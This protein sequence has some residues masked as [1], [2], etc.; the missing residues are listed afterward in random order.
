[1]NSYL[2]AFLF[3]SGAIKT[4]T[5]EFLGVIEDF[6]KTYYGI[7]DDNYFEIFSKL[8]GKNYDTQDAFVE[9]AD[10]DYVPP[11]GYENEEE[12]DED[13]YCSEIEDEEEDES[14]DEDDTNE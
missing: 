10:A 7:I 4:R 5:K 14:M 8:S 13:E 9:D 3:F 1:M 2:I 11:K 6:G 12:N